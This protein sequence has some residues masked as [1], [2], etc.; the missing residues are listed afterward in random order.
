MTFRRSPN[1]RVQR[2]CLFRRRIEIGDRWH[3]DA[4]S[5][6]V[7]FCGEF[8]SHRSDRT[9]RASNQPSQ[10]NPAFV[11][12]QA[13]AKAAFNRRLS[14]SSRSSSVDCNAGMALTPLW[15]NREQMTSISE[16][17][18][19]NRHSISGPAR[20][21]W[22][23]NIKRLALILSADAVAW[24]STISSSSEAR[25][26]PLASSCS[27]MPGTLSI[28]ATRS[29]STR[30]PSFCAGSSATAPVPSSS[31]A[32]HKRASALS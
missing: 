24:S 14:G 23:G 27:R 11:P 2:K 8:L 31:R 22:F 12:C 10:S 4:T 9:R 30:S 18:H 3:A 16:S 6:I 5:E 1:W 15:C 29:W 32:I 25:Q 21:G 13:I 7:I 26:F 19:S 20:E 28:S 17:E